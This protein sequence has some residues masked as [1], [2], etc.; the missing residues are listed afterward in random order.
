MHTITT[1]APKGRARRITTV[2][3]LA[4]GF[5]TFWLSFATT[6]VAED[7]LTTIAAPVER[8]YPYKILGLQPGDPLEDVLSVYAERSDEA[9]T[10]EREVVR[11]QSPEGNV[12]E[13]TYQ[14]FTRIGD[15]GLNGR[16]AGVAQDQITARLASDVMEQRPLAIYR[17]MRQPSEELPEPLELRAQL[18][19]LYGPAS[20]VAIAGREMVML[21]AWSEDGFITDLDAMGP[22]IHEETRTSGNRTSTL[23]T[24]YEICG[25]AQHYTNTVDYRFRY[26]R[27]KE[28]RP[29]CIATFTVTHKGEPGMTSIS[30]ELVDYE[31]GRLH[32]QEL[33]RQ[34]VEALI[35]EEIEASDMDL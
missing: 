7:S 33:D 4:S 9:P 6:A 20:R 11:V 21:Y 2:I 12:F 25:T 17:S 10:S 1:Q 15:V 30:F 34:I 3:A 16:L 14:L 26:P 8:P 23:S 18:E 29:G 22:L 32:E 13:F 28:I 27:E 31:L 5:L 35:G 19:E 24:Q